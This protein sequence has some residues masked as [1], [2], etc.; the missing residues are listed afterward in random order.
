[1]PRL[2]LKDF[3]GHLALIVTAEF[4]PIDRALCRVSV[5]I[6]ATLMPVLEIV[7]VALDGKARELTDDNFPAEH[8]IS[9]PLCERRLN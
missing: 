7:L 4:V 2:K 8:I 6:Q 9:P 3:A 5:E 1:L